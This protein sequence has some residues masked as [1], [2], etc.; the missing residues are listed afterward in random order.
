MPYRHGDPLLGLL[1]G[2]GVDA[3]VGHETPDQIGFSRLYEWGGSKRD[4][5]RSEW[6]RTDQ[7]K[8]NEM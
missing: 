8:S 6:N 1:L 2:R 7:N 4:Q 3:H 5:N